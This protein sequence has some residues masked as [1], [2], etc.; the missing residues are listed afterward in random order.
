[1]AYLSAGIRSK[2]HIAPVHLA[3]FRAMV[4]ELR[5]RKIELTV[6]F[7][8]IHPFLQYANRFDGPH[9]GPT[10]ADMY[11]QLKREVAKLTDFYDFSSYNALIGEDIAHI[12]YFIDD[13]HYRSNL[14]LLVLKALNGQ[15]DA[16]LPESFGVKVTAEN[17][18]DFI[19]AERRG[20]D[21]WA[22]DYP[23]YSKAIRDHFA[24]APLLGL[25]P[26]W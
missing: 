21:Q 8:P 24:H 11:D 7:A 9:E 25:E 2:V 5:R 6:Y 20:I 10:R 15:R 16:N 3:Y 22:E 26:D 12:K 1:M 14:G 17:V 19:A 18:E 13:I 4:M 23:Q